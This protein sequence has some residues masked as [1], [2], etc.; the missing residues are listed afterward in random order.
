[1]SEAT[2]AKSDTIAAEELSNFV[3]SVGRI[4]GWLEQTI[5]GQEETLD[6]LLQCAVTGSHALLVGAPGLAKTLMV[7]A[8]AAAADRSRRRPLHAVRP[9]LPITP[10]ASWARPG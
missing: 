8:M 4:R 9:S 5:V 6:Q 10:T 3:Q 1:M 2:A 7:K